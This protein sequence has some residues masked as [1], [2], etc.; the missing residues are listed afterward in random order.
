MIILLCTFRVFRESFTVAIVQAPMLRREMRDECGAQKTHPNMYKQITY[1]RYHE[2]FQR[3][4]FANEFEIR[5][6]LHQLRVT[7]ADISFALDEIFHRLVSRKNFE[8]ETTLK[9][10]FSWRSENLHCIARMHFSFISFLNCGFSG[11]NIQELEV[12]F[13]AKPSE[14]PAN[15]MPSVEMANSRERNEINFHSNLFRILNNSQYLILALYG[16]RIKSAMHV[17]RPCTHTCGRCTCSRTHRS[18]DA[19]WR[20]CFRRAGHHGL[21]GL[22]ACGKWALHRRNGLS[23]GWRHR[24]LLMDSASFALRDANQWC[25]QLLQP[26]VTMLSIT[27]NLVKVQLM[28]QFKLRSRVT[29]AVHEN[30]T[31]ET[32]EKKR[33][34][35]AGW[36][37]RVRKVDGMPSRVLKDLTSISRA[38]AT[39]QTVLRNPPTLSN[40]KNV[41]RSEKPREREVHRC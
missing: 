38:V 30:D 28:V 25:R 23:L 5:D 41:S 9:L 31:V 21:V 26:A 6:R 19:F 35:P 24:S 33:E 8:L 7:I 18:A 2:D 11:M 34:R 32:G 15:D 40:V 12:H 20:G 14:C 13:E 17:R 3:S 29:L 1:L 27:R 10:Q 39:L 4:N 22:K 16:P 36:R 37:T